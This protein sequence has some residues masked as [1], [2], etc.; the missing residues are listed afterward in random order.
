MLVVDDEPAL[1]RLM[2]D[3]LA[4]MGYVP[5]GFTSSVEALAAFRAYPDRFDA[6]ITDERMPVMSGSVLIRELRAIRASIPILLLS[7]Y[8]GGVIAHRAVEAGA[9]ELLKKPLSTLDLTN[10]LARLFASR[11]ASPTVHHPIA[12]AGGPDTPSQDRA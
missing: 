9:D 4:E 8:L 5:V 2:T 6:V 7:G 10:A 11:R 1:V 3:K 12:P